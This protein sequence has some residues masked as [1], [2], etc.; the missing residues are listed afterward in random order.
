MKVYELLHHVEVQVEIV[1]CY[2][3][4]TKYERKIIT[5]EQANGKEIRYIYIED[6]TLYI[7]VDN[8]END[9]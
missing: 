5:N 3:D 6:D 8:D 4:Y 9:L 1:F 2:Y 7:E